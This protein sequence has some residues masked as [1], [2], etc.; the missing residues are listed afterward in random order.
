MGT[1]RREEQ[2]KQQIVEDFCIILEDGN[3]SF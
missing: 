1:G 3:V 2:E